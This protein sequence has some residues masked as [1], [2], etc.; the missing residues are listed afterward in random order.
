VPLSLLLD[1]ADALT[2]A[3][4]PLRAV[5]RVSP[6]LLD[7]RVAIDAIE[8]AIALGQRRYH[9]YRDEMPGRRTAVEEAA[10]GHLAAVLA[11][12]G[13]PLHEFALLSLEPA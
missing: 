5:V 10:R 8:G 11:Q 2:G 13:L 6:P 9:L 7:P 3:A 1:R 12:E 4:F